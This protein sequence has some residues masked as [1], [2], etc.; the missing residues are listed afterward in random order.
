MGDKRMMKLVQNMHF[1]LPNLP[2]RRVADILEVPIGVVEKILAMKK[3]LPIVYNESFYFLV[4]STTY[5]T[6]LIEL[7]GPP[8]VQLPM[9]TKPTIASLEL[10][11]NDV[12][13]AKD[14]KI[15]KTFILTESPAPN[16]TDRPNTYELSLKLEL[17]SYELNLTKPP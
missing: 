14:Q 12:L 10:A 6:V 1:Q 17:W 2:A 13:V 3:L 7:L 16:D 9:A 5:D 8:K 4:E 11:V 15:Q